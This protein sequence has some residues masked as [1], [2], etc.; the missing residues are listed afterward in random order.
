MASARKRGIGRR[1]AC[2]VFTRRTAPDGYARL[3]H[4][5]PLTRPNE[6]AR[7]HDRAMTKHKNPAAST[8][9][10]TQPGVM[11]TPIPRAV[12]MA[13]LMAQPGRIGE[14]QGATTADFQPQGAARTARTT[15]CAR[16]R[17]TARMLRREFNERR[18]HGQPARCHKG[19][20][21]PLVTLLGDEQRPHRVLGCAITGR[22]ENS[23]SHEARVA[24]H[25][26]ERPSRYRAAHSVGPFAHACE[27]LRA[28]AVHERHV[29]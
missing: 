1:G 3:Q 26:Q 25:H 14:E 2:H 21:W 4:A 8:S 13:F 23:A 18:C 29:R 17:S 20:G 11:A 7:P 16:G 27:Q 28:H 19:G 24:Q 10:L 5:V 22:A 6:E 9:R 12:A 15:T